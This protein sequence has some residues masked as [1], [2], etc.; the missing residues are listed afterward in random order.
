MLTA[1]RRIARCPEILPL[2]QRSVARS[3]GNPGATGVP[4]GSAW[5]WEILSIEKANASR[6]PPGSSHVAVVA[7]LTSH[8]LTAGTAGDGRDVFVE[9][10]MGRRFRPLYKLLHDERRDRGM[11][12][13]YDQILPGQPFDTVWVYELP[14]NARRL[15]LLL[16]FGLELPFESPT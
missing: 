7:R 6:A 12:D 2:R 15:R 1:L 3:G 14:A 4:P 8:S 10:W 9:D 5:D 13:P 16:P 11:P